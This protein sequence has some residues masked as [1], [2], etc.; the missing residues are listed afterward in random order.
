M[1]PLQDPPS[2]TRA[3]NATMGD[4]NAMAPMQACAK[5][6]CGEP[7]DAAGNPLNNTRPFEDKVVGDEGVA[8]LAQLAAARA[9]GGPPFY[10][11][12]GFRK[13]HLPHRHPS[14]YD[15]LYNLSG[16]ATAKFPVLDASVPPIA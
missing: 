15:G 5:A 9:A 14:W 7:G 3:P 16:L 11:A 13:P 2:W 8:L 6:G 4:V 12:V 10:L 1:P